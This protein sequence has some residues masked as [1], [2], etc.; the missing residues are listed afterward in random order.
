[1]NEHGLEDLKRQI[2]VLLS[3]K[4]TKFLAVLQFD[5]LSWF[6]H[7]QRA[8][9]LSCLHCFECGLHSI[10]KYQPAG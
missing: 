5:D 4:K 8:H 9:A 7:T 6:F 2:M 3:V 10:K 1:M